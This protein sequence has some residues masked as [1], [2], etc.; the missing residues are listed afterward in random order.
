MFSRPLRAFC[1]HNRQF[2]IQFTEKMFHPYPRQGLRSKPYL[3]LSLS[4][5]LSLLDDP[6]QLIFTGLPVYPHQDLP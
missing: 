5:S 4:L 2:L 3:S 1:F 6:P